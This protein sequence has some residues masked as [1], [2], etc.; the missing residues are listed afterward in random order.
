M[1]EE[2]KRAFT[3]TFWWWENFEWKNSIP[4]FSHLI[5]PIHLFL[6]LQIFDFFSSCLKVELLVTWKSEWSRWYSSR[7]TEREREKKMEG[8]RFFCVS[9]WRKSRRIDVWWWWREES[10]LTKLWTEILSFSFILSLP[11][12]LSHS[13]VSSFKLHLIQHRSKCISTLS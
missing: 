8:F 7:D 4:G 11:L 9:D 2:R 1:E 10:A 6:M 13:L 3:F 12:F 5:H